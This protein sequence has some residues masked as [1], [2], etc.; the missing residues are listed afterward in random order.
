MPESYAPVI[1]A[2]KAAK[3]R[4]ETGNQ[5]IVA[6]SDLESKS[7]NY[8]ITHVMTRPFRMLIH[9]SIVLFTCIYL[10]L[11][12]AIF[13]LYFEAYPI[14]F[15][16]PDSI[17]HF[18]AGQTGLAF[19]PIG[20]GASACSLLFLVYDSYLARAQARKAPWSQIEEYRRLPLAC[21]GGPLY[22][23]SLFWIGWSAYANV[24][25]IVPILSG[26][27]FGMGF[28]LIFMAMLNYLTDA[29]ET[30]AASAQGIASTCRSVFGALLPLASK[31]MFDALGIHWA[32]SLLAFL[33]LG[34]TII[35]FVFIRY[36]DRIRAGSKFC[37]ELKELKA[38]RKAEEEEEEEGRRLSA[39]EDGVDLRKEEV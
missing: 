15:Q 4:K 7:W 20:I 11:A 30:F 33:S 19:L 8:V 38:A 17:Y 28:L 10:S 39:R 31:S 37:Q 24:H 12:Y 5:N 23:I 25:W 27:T 16:G 14:I 26:I 2:R 32:C 35:P 18:N 6:R 34:V 13:Y 29:Y 36:G 21:V 1:L 22:V 9:E 3:M